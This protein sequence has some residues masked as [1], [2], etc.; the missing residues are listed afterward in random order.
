AIG[1][2]FAG[3]GGGRKPGGWVSGRGPA[4]PAAPPGG[5][6]RLGDRGLGERRGGGGALDHQG[7]LGLEVVVH[8][9]D[10][11]V[12]PGL[13]EGQVVDGDDLVAGDRLAGSAAAGGQLALQL[14][15]R[16]A[17]RVVEPDLDPVLAVAL[18]RVRPELEHELHLRVH[19][20]ELRD[21]DPVEDAHD[22]E[23]PVGGHVRVVREQGEFDLHRGTPGVNGQRAAKRESRYPAA[24]GNEAARR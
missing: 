1:G 20:G 2:N 6:S 16:L 24:S 14:E 17:V 3:S 10:E 18:R 22:V 12:L 7:N 4:P 15:D 8:E 5:S 13:R 9:D 21:G 19:G 11:V 23:L